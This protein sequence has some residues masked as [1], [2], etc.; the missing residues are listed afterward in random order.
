MKGGRGAALVMA[1]FLALGAGI[2]LGANMWK[3][4][5]RVARVYAEGNRIVTEREILTLAAIPKDEKLFAVDL[6]AAR[7]RVEGNQFIRSASVKREAPDGIRIAVV[8][9]TPIAALVLDRILYVDEEGYVLPPVKSEEI[10]D[11]PV[12]TGDLPAAECTPGHRVTATNIREALEILSVA[13]NVGDELYHL[14]SEVHLEGGK[15]IVLFTAESGVPVVFGHGDAVIKMVTFDGFWKQIV[16]QRGATELK[17][18]DLR[19][20][21][22]VV[23][24]WQNDD[25]AVVQ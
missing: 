9:R 19:Y 24:R 5:L 17:T 21:D 11:L 23:V 6:F 10:F 25:D 2:T 16:M 15:D 7:R 12:L 18:V 1:L 22:Q 13:R 3:K 4:D 14:I 8:E 20:T